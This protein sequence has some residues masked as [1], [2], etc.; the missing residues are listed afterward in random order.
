MTQPSGGAAACGAAARTSG[1]AGN[2]GGASSAHP[3]RVLAASCVQSQRSVLFIPRSNQTQTGTP[4]TDGN[5][6]HVSDACG[7]SCCRC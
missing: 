2:T 4:C 3:L 5:A 1:T 6:V 7:L